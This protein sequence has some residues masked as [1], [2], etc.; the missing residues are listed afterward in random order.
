MEVLFDL[1]EEAKL[2]CDELGITMARSATV[3]T[4]P[5]FVGMLVELIGERIHGVSDRRAVGQYP[6]NH[7]VCPINCCM[8]PARPMAARPVGT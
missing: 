1:D 6:V 7:D 2:K 8:P 5:R 3:G 4:D